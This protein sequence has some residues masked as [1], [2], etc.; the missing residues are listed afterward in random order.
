MNTADIIDIILVV[1][2]V[3]AAYKGWR[4]GLIIEVFS[5]LALILAVYGCVRFSFYASEVISQQFPSLSENYLKIISVAATFLAILFVVNL[6]GKLLTK[7]A[8]MAA[9]GTVNRVLG[10]TFGIIKISIIIGMIIWQYNHMSRSFSF[11]IISSEKL[12]NSVLYPIY[13]DLSTQILPA[14]ETAKL[15]TEEII[16]EALPSLSPLD[17]ERDTSS[18]KSPMERERRDS[19]F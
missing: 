1:L 15:Q 9:L 6:I 14:F 5:L 8:G 4:K 17:D 10:A 2:L 7:V 19:V 18:I 13:L 11:E 3:F 12:S 16:E